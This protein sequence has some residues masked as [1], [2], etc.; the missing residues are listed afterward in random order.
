MSQVL[1][2]HSTLGKSASAQSSASTS[3]AG[4]GEC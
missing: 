1:K 2:L 4:I 3:A